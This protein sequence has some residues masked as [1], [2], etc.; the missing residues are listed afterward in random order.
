MFAKF[1]RSKRQPKRK[2]KWDEV[3]QSINEPWEGDD[4]VDA[5]S[6]EFVLQ[7]YF[8][9]L[10]FSVFEGSDASFVAADDVDDDD[11]TKKKKKYKR[12]TQSKRQSSATPRQR[13]GPKSKQVQKFV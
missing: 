1:G 9:I 4:D 6:I 8:G 2:A 11:E 10:K 12:R 7:N 13:P 3:M 5:K